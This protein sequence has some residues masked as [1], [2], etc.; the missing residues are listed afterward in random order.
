ME[1][2]VVLMTDAHDRGLRLPYQV[3]SLRSAQ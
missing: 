1:Y 2:L 3:R